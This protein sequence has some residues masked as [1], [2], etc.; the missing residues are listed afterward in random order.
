MK[1]S[2]RGYLKLAGIPDDAL[3]SYVLPGLARHSLLS[4]GVLCDA[5]MTAHLDSDKIEIFYKED[6]ILSGVRDSST[7]G[8]WMIDIPVDDQHLANNIYPTGTIAKLVA[9]YHGCFCSPVIST[10]KKVLELGTRLPGINLK[11]INKY[12]PIS[13]AT[14]AG[15]LKGTRWVRVRKSLQDQLSQL[16]VSEGE[17]PTQGDFSPPRGQYIYT[18][19]RP[20]L[21]GLAHGDMTGEH[22]IRSRQGNIILLFM[23]AED[24]SYI[25]MELVQDREKHS[26]TKAFEDSFDFLAKYE[27][28]PTF[29]RLDNEKSTLF[30]RMCETRHVG[31]QYVP[32]GQHRA[33]KAE[34]AIQ[35]GIYHY[36][37]ALATAD[38]DFPPDEWDRLKEHVEITLNLMRPSR[39]NPLIS[40]Y[41]YLRG[42]FIWEHTPLGPPG[43]SIMVLTRADKRPTWNKHGPVGFY[44]GPVL[45]HR[46]C[47]QVY[48]TKTKGLRI[49]D[50]LAWFPSPLAPPV[51]TKEDI[52]SI[53]AEDLKDAAKM[54]NKK[55]I[56]LSGVGMSLAS[57]LRKLELYIEIYHAWLRKSDNEDSEL[58]FEQL[59]PPVMEIPTEESKLDI[60]PP[61]N[62]VSKNR[63]KSVFSPNRLPPM[64]FNPNLSLHYEIKPTATPKASTSP[65]GQT[66]R[67]SEKSTPVPTAE[68]ISPT[69]GQP[70][71]ETQKRI[72]N[73]PIVLPDPSEDS[74]L[75]WNGIEHVPRYPRRKPKKPEH[76]RDYD[77]ANMVE[78]MILA[79]AIEAEHLNFDSDG[80]QL[81]Y[82]TAT[83]GPNAAKWK[84]AFLEELV[85]LTEETET[86]SWNGYQTIPK[87]TIP[88]Y[89]SIV[90]KEKVGED[91]TIKYRV[92]L[93]VGG[94]RV[95]Y[96]GDRSS[97]TA[98]LETLKV[99][100]N[101]WVSR[102]IKWSTADIK[103][104]YLGSPMDEVVYMYI[105]EKDIPESF[106]IKHH[107]EFRNGKALVSIHK[108][109]YGLPHAG[110]LAQDLLFPHLEKHGYHQCARTDCLFR[111][112]TDDIAF[113][114]VVDDFGILH[115]DDRA[116]ENLFRVLRLQ[117]TITTDLTGGKFL[118]IDIKLNSKN[119][120]VSLSMP[121]YVESALKRFDVT[122]NSE[123]THSPLSYHPIIHGPQMESVDTS[124]RIDAARVKR[125]QQIIG[126]FLYYARAVDESML[127]AL[128]KLASRQAN[129]TEEAG[130]RR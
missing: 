3:K 125:I 122:L 121:G 31:L 49:S 57:N 107:I 68:Q 92:R 113:M 64:P 42:P 56:S 38:P 29:V 105:N 47:F 75:G 109:M 123:G 20:L 53:A 106:K 24:A 17:N 25:H 83:C 44:L 77:C 34:R 96:S 80:K 54:L 5:G 51:P 90:V 39:I 111:H 10:F 14:A 35:T 94:D 32:P 97:T 23:F 2:H 22:P 117:Y 59:W 41:E 116:L 36:V 84:Q 69:S 87:G 115:A 46:G 65:V 76:L 79:M 74:S 93:T 86:I 104:F 102:E 99:L 112:E 82:R 108:G 28:H 70:S 85:R 16:E 71:L 98:S 114:V 81:T 62:T 18:T 110:K 58:L 19:E 103:D 95:Q 40:A 52:L 43:A 4:L 27:A 91:G 118:G 9:F 8:M 12:P 21:T 124:P 66:I 48:V 60:P 50:S 126:V 13:A 6:L 128:N 119:G 55:D 1:S 78:T 15:H 26:L 120:S 63:Q 130:K 89:C 37:S 61:E 7:S 73:D 100:L 101:I 33:L 72:D 88:T 30:E 127:C 67:N 45:D 129:P 11:D